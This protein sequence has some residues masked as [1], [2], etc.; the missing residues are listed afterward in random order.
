MNWTDLDD[1]HP[2]G[3]PSSSDRLVMERAARAHIRLIFD[4]AL[5]DHWSVVHALWKE[6]TGEGDWFAVAVWSGLPNPL[7]QRLRDMETPQ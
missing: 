4:A 5:H 7:R 2:L 1:A 6:A 3:I